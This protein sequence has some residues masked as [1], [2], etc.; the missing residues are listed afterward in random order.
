MTDGAPR[1]SLRSRL[2]RINFVVLA[3]ASVLVTAC[4]ALSAVCA[5]EIPSLALRI[6]TSKPLAWEFMRS[7]IARPAASSFALLTRRPEDRRC[8]EVARLAWEVERLR[9]AFSD[10]ALVLIVAAILVLLKS[11]QDKRLGLTLVRLARC[12]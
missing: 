1:V 11:V 4:I 12:V 7:A 6:A 2:A 3:F 10:I 5:M 8:T 9:C